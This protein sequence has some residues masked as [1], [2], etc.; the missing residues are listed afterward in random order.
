MINWILMDDQSMLNRVIDDSSLKD[1]V[2]FKHS[3]SC[4]ISL[5]AKKRLEDDWDM[6]EKITPYYLDVKTNRN[7]SLQIAERFSVEHESPQIL[8]I[9]NGEC[10]YDA[11]HFDITI[12]ELKET[13]DF[14][15]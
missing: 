5:M 14:H 11:S 15:A 13:L 3:T 10:I 4:S 7:L 1:V 12:S 8:L 6:N 2:V 9:R